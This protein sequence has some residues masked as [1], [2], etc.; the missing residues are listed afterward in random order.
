MVM[1]PPTVHR[2]W[3]DD[4]LPD[5]VAEHGKAWAQAHPDWQITDWCDSAALPPLINQD[6]FNAAA[7]YYPADWKRFQA[8][9]LRLELLW[10]HGGVYADTDTV[11]R[12][13]LQPL[14][15]ERSCVVAHSPQH[16]RGDHP[17]TNCVMA[18]A[19][20]HPWVRALIDGIPDA[21]AEY[22]HRTL[23]QSV[24]PWHLTRT[25][26]DGHWPDVTVLDSATMF[27]ADGWVEHSWNNAAR[28]RGES[29]F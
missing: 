15:Q 18:A 25:Y 28:K 7:E 16:I 19:P 23:A 4:P 10:L 27:G 24:G 14:L 11:P 12:R 22:G 21:L 5:P 13:N 29:L 26:R 17:I 8:D 20:G 9:L 6:A 1:I 2:I 3:L